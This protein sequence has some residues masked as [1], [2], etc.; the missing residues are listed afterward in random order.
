MYKKSNEAPT[1]M[2]LFHAGAGPLIYRCIL[3]LRDKLRQGPSSSSSFFQ[4]KNKLN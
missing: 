3:A 4:I 2:K 1:P